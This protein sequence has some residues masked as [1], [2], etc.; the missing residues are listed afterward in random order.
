MSKKLLELKDF[1]SDDEHKEETK[2]NYQQSHYW[3][4]M[5]VWD[6]VEA[7]WRCTKK[8]YLECLRDIMWVIDIEEE[9]EAT[10]C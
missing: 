10:K 1:L 6:L 4:L 2:S 3:L 9:M 8:E 5:L 7:S